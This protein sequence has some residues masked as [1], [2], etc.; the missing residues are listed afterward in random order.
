MPALTQQK[1][2]ILNKARPKTRVFWLI[3]ASTTAMLT[4]CSGRAAT[5]ASDTRTRFNEEHVTIYQDASMNSPIVGTAIE[6]G[7]PAKNNFHADVWVLELSVLGDVN[8]P[9]ACGVVLEHDR[10][11]KPSRYPGDLSFSENST[12]ERYAAIPCSEKPDSTKLGWSDGSVAMTGHVEYKT[13]GEDD[14]WV[15]HIDHISRAPRIATFVPPNA[16]VW[17]ASATSTPGQ[18]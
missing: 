13:Y 3:V 9:S 1:R 16:F 7:T 14:E 8:H 11:R 18:P 17:S 6:N 12:L 10:Q 15:Y 4:A 2:R 5:P